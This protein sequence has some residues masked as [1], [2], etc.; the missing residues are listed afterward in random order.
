M[1]TTCIFCHSDLKRNEAIEEFPVGRRL[2]FDGA[3]GRLWV[4]C[5]RCERWN[6]SPLETRWEAIEACERAFE[7]TRMRVASDNIGLAKLKE[8]LELVRVGDPVRQ[9]FAA[10][11]YG[12]QFGRRRKRAMLVTGAGAAAVGALWA[13]GFVSL[14]GLW[15]GTRMSQRWYRNRVILRTRDPRGLPVRVQRKHLYT[16]HLVPADDGRGWGLRVDYVP[17]HAGGD[18]RKTMIVHG[19][20]ALGLAGQLMAQANRRGGKKDEIRGA[21]R[22]IE[23][24]GHP[25]AFLPEAAEL[26]QRALRRSGSVA[27]ESPSWGDGRRADLAAR[28]LEK[29]RKPL[30]GSLAGLNPGLR[31]AIEM[32]THEET[33]REALEGELKELEARWREAEEIAR[34]A[35]NLF[36]PD[37]V[38]DF[39]EEERAPPD[40]DPARPG[41]DPANATKNA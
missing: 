32:A 35:D 40:G 13:G 3:R 20:E 11:R 5:R 23:R 12:D 6:L 17:G 27:R 2:A 25:E 41:F 7:S 1:Y 18:R 38:E 37:S 21:V 28:E 15:I 19:R 22:R 33:E 10:W 34:I 29:L 39:I 16:S 30:P 14:G 8:G 26:A 24:A 36:V 4:V 9:E 31:L